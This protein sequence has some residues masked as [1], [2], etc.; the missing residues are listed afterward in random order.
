MSTLGPAPGLPGAL[1]QRSSSG[2]TSTGTALSPVEAARL[3]AEARAQAPSTAPPVSTPAQAHSPAFDP[4]TFNPSRQ[5]VL[6]FHTLLDSQLLPKTSK[7]QA[8]ATLE[9]LL[10]LCT[11]ILDPPTPQQAAKFRQIRLSNGLIRRNI[12]DVAGGAPHDYLVACS[13]RRQTI[14]FTA[15]LVFP[16]SPSAKQLHALRTGHHVLELTLKRA[17]EADE[18]EKRYRESEKEAEKMRKRQ[19]LLGFEEDRRLRAERDARERIVREARAAVPPDPGVPRSSTSPI[20]SSLRHGVIASA[21]RFS[22]TAALPDEEEDGMGDPPPSYGEL[23][24]RVL[25]TGLPPQGEGSVPGGVTMVAAQDLEE[26][27]MEE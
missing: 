19:A 12:M 2:S 6:P 4:A 25:A 14:D 1:P 16:P 23:H 21:A 27:E 13:F 10:T 26:E 22:G 9:T 20:S 17:R 24:G 5:D 18:R 11:N 7:A 15:Y 3:A 8:V